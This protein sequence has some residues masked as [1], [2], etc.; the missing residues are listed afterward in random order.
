MF[1]ATIFI[2][3]RRQM[4]LQ[5]FK[6]ICQGKALFFFFERQLGG[7]SYAAVYCAFICNRS[8]ILN[9]ASSC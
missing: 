2:V 1:S 6:C 4:W 9:F 5:T 7:G 8:N 3:D